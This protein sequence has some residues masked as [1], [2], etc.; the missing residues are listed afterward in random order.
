LKLEV[1]G[2][3]QTYVD[4]VVGRGTGSLERCPVDLDMM[5]HDVILGIVGTA[6]PYPLS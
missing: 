3:D 6:Q 4:Y 5:I 2:D 1:V